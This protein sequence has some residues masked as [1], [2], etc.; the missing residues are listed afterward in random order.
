MDAVAWARSYNLKN[1]T[2][3]AQMVEAIRKLSAEGG[4]FAEKSE[5]VQEKAVKSF[6]ELIVY[7]E[8]TL[9][10]QRDIHPG[11]ID[12]AKASAKPAEYQKKYAE[13]E[14]IVTNEINRQYRHFS[15]F[16]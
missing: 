7:L 2:N 8:S 15:M 12:L 11:K 4:F 16:L 5:H 1:P 14:K 6:C 3:Q 9:F 10:Y 13:V